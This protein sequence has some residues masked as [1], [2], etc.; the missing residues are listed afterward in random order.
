MIN[1]NEEGIAFETKPTFIATE[2]HGKPPPAWL[3]TA[4]GSAYAVLNV[5]SRHRRWQRRPAA[6]GAEGDSPHLRCKINP[7]SPEI[8]RIHIVEHPPTPLPWS[9]ALNL[10]HV[11]KC[12]V[13]G[14]GPTVELVEDN[15]RHIG[16]PSVPVLG[17]MV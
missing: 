16:R 9:L 2:M 13:V 6:A 3:P 17:S 5:T 12:S 10:F 15:S 14:I 4:E 11:R 1:T 7:T 8:K